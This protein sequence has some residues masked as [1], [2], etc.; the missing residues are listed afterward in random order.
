MVSSMHCC[1][2]KT[3]NRF[4]YSKTNARHCMRVFSPIFYVLPCPIHP[5]A[6]LIRS[7][8][9]G[10]RHSILLAVEGGLDGFAVSFSVCT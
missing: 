1:S 8:T 7:D 9:I 3:R 5:I 4:L 10:C 6:L 2:F